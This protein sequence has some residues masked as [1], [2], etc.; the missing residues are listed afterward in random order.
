MS[1]GTRRITHITECVGMEGEQVTTQDI[2]VFERTGL[3]DKGKVLGRFKPTGIR[4]K[5]AEK[6]KACGFSLPA[7]MFQTVVEIL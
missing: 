7:E 4:P 5:F 2:F 1:D 3:G 6:L